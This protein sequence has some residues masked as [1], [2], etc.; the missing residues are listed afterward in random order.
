M[1]P[2]WNSEVFRK[3]D[4]IEEGVESAIRNNPLFSDLNDTEMNIV[5]K[6][7]NVRRYKTGEIVFEQNQSGIG[8]YM[9]AS[10]K[11]SIESDKTYI[12]PKTGK[13]KSKIISKEPLLQGDFFGEAS[14]VEDEGIRTA[15]ARVMEPTVLVS[16]FKPEFLKIIKNRNVMGS[17]ISFKL[18]GV[19]AKR[20]KALQS[21]LAEI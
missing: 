6:A 15:T 3:K 17:K 5:K 16:F 19:L 14:L 20:L 10:G 9:V 13:E 4:R 2:I 11:V 8:M 18:A 1:K 7:V 21:L 12:D